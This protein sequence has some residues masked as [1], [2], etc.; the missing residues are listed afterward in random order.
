ME[1]FHT[2]PDVSSFSGLSGDK[3]GTR[4]L[5]EGYN[6]F[7]SSEQRGPAPDKGESY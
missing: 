6:E 7:P 4:L 1:S 3:A 5:N 2:L